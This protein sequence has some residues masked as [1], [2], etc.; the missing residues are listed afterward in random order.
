MLL[1]LTVSDKNKL[2]KTF[3]HE[4]ISINNRFFYR[5]T[6]TLTALIGI[7]AGKFSD[8]LNELTATSQNKEEIN[9]LITNIFLEVIVV[10]DSR[11]HIAIL[12][13]FFQAANSSSYIQ[14]AF[15]LLIPV[16]QVGAM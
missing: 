12:L 1:L 3:A 5:L 4:T 7:V 13:F 11:H 8:K 2:R 6:T 9:S 10:R 14:D 15:Q 16:L